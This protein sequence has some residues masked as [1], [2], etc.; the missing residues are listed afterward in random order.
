MNV[1]TVVVIGMTAG[2]A[3]AAGPDLNRADEHGNRA[4]VVARDSD[5]V[6]GGGHTRGV[7]DWTALGPFGGDVDDVRAMP[8]N[9]DIVLAGIAPDGSIGGTL[10]RSTDAGATWTEVSA[11]SGN[12]VFDIAYAADGTAYIGTMD[13]IFKS[14]DEGVTWTNL[15]LGIGLN[16]QVFDIALDPVQTNTIWV[17]LASSTTSNVMRS[18]DGGATWQN[19]T[20]AGAAGT[21]CMGIALDPNSTNTVAA[22]FSGSFGGGSVWVSNNGGA[23]WANRTAGLPANPMNEIA[24]DGTM[25][26]VCGG[27]AF[28]SQEVGLYASPDEGVTW[29]ALHDGSW[30]SLIV[31]DLAVNGNTILAATNTGLMVSDDAGASWTG[32]ALGTE[33]MSLNAVRIDQPPVAYVGASS[34]GILKSTDTATSFAPS[35]T[36]IGALDVYS[37]EANPNDTS[38]M[39]LSFQ[40]LNN[41]GIYT[42]TDAGQTWT[43]EPLPGTRYNDVLFAPD[44]TLYVLSDGPSTIAP[45]GVYRRNGDGTWTSL[46]PDQGT[47][48]E[49]ELFA[50]RFSD[51]DPNLIMIGGSDFGVAGNEP[52]IW[53][54]S[55]AGTSWTKQYEGAN[56]F[57]DVQD[58][59][60]VADGTDQVMLACFTDFGEQTGGALRTTDGG[61]SWVPAD[62]GLPAG[63]QG[64]ALSH[65]PESITSFFYADGDTGTG[66]GGLYKT[67]DAGLNWSL[68]GDVGTVRD[69]VADTTDPMIVY[70]MQW[71]APKVGRSEDGGVSFTAFDSG[72]DNVGTARDLT[73]AGSRLLLAA[74]TGS[75]A[76]D[77]ADCPPDWNGDT[78]LNSQDF[79]AFLN[80][81]VA[82]NADYDGDTTTNSQDFIAFLNDFVA[83]C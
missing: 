29:T 67:I 78:V 68:I 43:L 50:I 38:E 83:G 7:G 23:S 14:T 28:G 61:E 17:G 71:S 53:K 24:N 4:P 26:Y 25:L 15:P 60:I 13:G 8:T 3:I 56:D 59:A 36:G 10:Y 63:A 37:V 16:D 48:F 18:T 73:I 19:L 80:D 52:T 57:E 11:F 41:G 75:W 46:G 40:G 6:G 9:T 12:S 21:S 55:D 72:L 20:P 54:S 79:I 81:F 33:N 51:S 62:T 69:V 5:A 35:S 58:L 2:V 39:A 42:S 27:M 49:T 44:G 30:P 34:I 66:N 22:C 70:I 31:H 74:S 32:P 77:L 76:T 1:P 82:G 47:H 65:S 45:E 64:Y